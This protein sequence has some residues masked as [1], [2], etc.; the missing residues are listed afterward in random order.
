MPLTDTACRNKKANGKPQK[1]V[2]MDGLYLFVSP[3][4]GKLWRMDYR[5]A[6]KRNTLSFGPYPLITLTAARSK[7]DEAKQALRDG[8]DPGLLRKQKQR[9]PKLATSNSFEIV[10]H[11]WLDNQKDQWT[12]KYADHVKTRLEADIFPVFGSRPIAEIETL[13]VLDALRKVEKRGAL[14]IAK[15]LRQ[16][17]GQIFRYAVI[18]GRAGRDPSADLKGALKAGGRPLHHRAMA[19]E[20][21][22][23]FLNSLEVYDGEVGTKLALQLIV[24]TFVRTGELRVAQ[25]TEFE[26][27]DGSAPIWRIPAARMK[28]RTEHLVPLSPAVVHILKGLRLLSGNNPY[29]FPSPS[30]GGTMSNNTMLFALYRLGYHGRATVHGF[31]GLASTCLN[32]A[33]F[34]SDWIERQLSHDERDT[35]RRAYNS[36]Q[37]L[38]DRRKM[39]QWWSDYLVKVA[40]TGLTAINQMSTAA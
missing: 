6:G 31:R 14:D 30:A 23:A 5:F 8:N 40:N 28:M 3:N 36:A 20:T 38:N 15:R 7:R 21:L 39:M 34:P 37:Y 25:W 33:G 35:V 18:T 16:T 24:H 29:L 10:A 19:R 13:E 22:P 9:D 26:D 32:E 27:L 2:D 12:P 17:C 1:F 4:G 11:E